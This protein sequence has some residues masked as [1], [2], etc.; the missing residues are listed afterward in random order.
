MFETTSL[1]F[2]RSFAGSLILRGLNYAPD[3]SGRATR[4]ELAFTCVISMA[5]ATALN[6]ATGW[7]SVLTPIT[8]FYLSLLA[9]LLIVAAVVRRL[10]DTN[11]RANALAMLFAPYI[12]IVAIG[13]ILCFDG[14]AGENIFGPDPRNS[15]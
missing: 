14:F 15:R 13:A 7:M 8:V 9:G 1:R 2:R 11:R 3:F 5:C 6:L 10:H 4:T 12:G